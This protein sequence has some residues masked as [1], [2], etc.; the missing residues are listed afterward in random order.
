MTS[1]TQEQKTEIERLY[2]LKILNKNIAKFLGISFHIVNNY[3]YKEYLV[4]NE[5]AKYTCSH[6]EKSDE[7]IKLYKDELPYK[8]IMKITGLPY[9]HICDIL[10]QTTFRRRQGIT[11]KNLREVQRLM[12]EGYKKSSISRKLDLPYGQVEYW[13][14]KIKSGVYT[15]LH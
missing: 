2:K 11:I 9:Y 14:K 1:L 5:R 4:K 13:V 10:K 12:E 7:V 8:E 6:L 15:S 3:L